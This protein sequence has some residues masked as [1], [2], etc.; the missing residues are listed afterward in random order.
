MTTNPSQRLD[1]PPAQ[2]RAP[3]RTPER[4]AERQVAGV[5]TRQ[6]RV[7]WGP[8]WAGAIVAVPVFLVLQ[9]FFFA[10]GALE[11]GFNV[12]VGSL[13]FS[14]ILGLIAFF[15]GGMMAGASSIWP[16]I[17][18]G[19]L[20]GVL[21]WA[22]SVVGLLILGLVGGGALLGP[23]ANL[24]GE[25]AI[26]Q[27]IAATDAAAGSQAAQQARVPAGWTALG[28]GLTAAAAALGGVLGSK[29]WPRGRSDTSMAP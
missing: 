15:I 27:Q 11:I 17:E 8:I 19:V 20:H 9:T 7:R 24:A 26:L 16:S 2:S 4:Q 1:H 22:L 25:A 10:V 6:D 12:G 28:L 14:A 21:V 13:I 18:D 5:G 3:E 29:L 23:L